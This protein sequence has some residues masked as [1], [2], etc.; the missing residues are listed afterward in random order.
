VCR[1]QP[2]QWEAIF[3]T[4]EEFSVP[5]TKYGARARLNALQ[6]YRPAD[7]PAISEARLNL[8]EAKLADEIIR[9]AETDPPLNAEQ[10]SRLAV[11]AVAIA[12]GWR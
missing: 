3:G 5:S 12:A 9:E 1:T 2:P 7:D 4:P 6:R 11:F 8:R 10:R